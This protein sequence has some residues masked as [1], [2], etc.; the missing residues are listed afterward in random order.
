MYFFKFDF[1]NYNGK[2]F[3]LCFSMKIRFNKILLSAA[4]AVLAAMGVA[5]AQSQFGGIAEFDKTV[6]DFG[7]VLTT[8]GPLSCKFTVSN[9]SAKPINIV[10]VVSSCGCTDVVWTREAIAPGA[11]GEIKAT[12]SN[13]EGTGT[14]DKTLTVYTSAQKKPVILHLKGSVKNAK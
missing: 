7:E 11:K 13:D 4:A 10:T 12:Y 8:D 3:A 6:H 5:S 2:I 1:T 14:F 9:I